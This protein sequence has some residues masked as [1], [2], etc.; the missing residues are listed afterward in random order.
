[1]SIVFSI[2]G[3]TL[4]GLLIRGLANDKSIAEKPKDSSQWVI[5]LVLSLI[6]GAIVWAFIPKNCDRNRDEDY[7]PYEYQRMSRD[8]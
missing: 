5:Q 4:L 2:I 3:L 7:D 1:M 6:V 8:D